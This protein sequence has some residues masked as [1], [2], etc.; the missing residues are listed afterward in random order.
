[1]NLQHNKYTSLSQNYNP[2]VKNFITNIQYLSPINWFVLFQEC[3]S[4]AVRL[5]PFTKDS[6]GIQ[7]AAVAPLRRPW[8]CSGPPRS[9]CPLAGCGRCGT[10]WRFS[11]CS[12]TA[13]ARPRIPGSSGW[14]QSPHPG[15]FPAS[16][17][18][19]GPPPRPSPPEAPER[20]Q[21]PISPHLQTRK[22]TK[23]TLKNGSLNLICFRRFRFDTYKV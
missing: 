21:R 3:K 12:G 7:S 11:S 5:I 6:A 22:G 10:P 14:A 1:M 15:S 4:T 13:A 19:G 23:M 17:P 18:P 16:L 2:N 20:C 8:P 9:R